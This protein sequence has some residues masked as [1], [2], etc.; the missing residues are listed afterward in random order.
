MAVLP[1]CGRGGDRQEDISGLRSLGAL[2][3]PLVSTPSLSAKAPATVEV[4]FYAAVPLGQT[5]TLT[6]FFDAGSS[7]GA[8]KLPVSAIEVETLSAAYVP[9]QT[10]TIFSQKVHLTVPTL[11][12]L[13]AASKGP[14]SG[15]QLT[16]GLTIAAGG[17]EE[18]IIANLNVFPAGASELAWTNPT[19]KI[20]A[21]TPLAAVSISDLV[22]LKATVAGG[23]GESQKVGWFVSQG[24]VTNRRA[25]STSWT[26]TKTETGPQTIIVTL[27]E[28]NTRGFAF[29]VVDVHSN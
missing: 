2:V 18:N 13:Q 27:H 10:L 7:E 9:H 15:I 4:T 29:D 20:M 3:N 25:A 5:A 8:F 1:G 23:V 17:I 19:V 11:D 12:Q 28:I 26:L 22:F 16:Y 14:F 24:S 6:P 21:P